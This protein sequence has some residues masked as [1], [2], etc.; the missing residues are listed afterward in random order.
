M[1]ADLP[2]LA[3]PGFRELEPYEPIDPPEVL[4]RELGLPAERIVKLDGNENPYGPS[5]LVG[6]ALARL[7]RYHLYPDPLQRELRDALA[8][9][10]GLGA[11]HIV[12]GSG[13]D[14]LLDVL[15]RLF[16]GPGEAVVISP[17]TFGMYTF[18]A[19][20]CGARVVEVPRRPDL[21]LDVEAVA[22]ALRD[23]ARLCFLASPNNPT[24]ELTPREAVEALLATGALVV[25][26]EAYMEFAEGGW[27]GGHL[28]VRHL[29]REHANLV[30]LRTFSKWAGLA[31]LRVGYGLFPRELA[32]LVLKVK[33]PYNVNVAAQA[34]AL[35]SLADLERLNARLRSLVAERERLLASL[36]G[37]GWLRPY[38]SQANFV[39]CR[40]EGLEA[41]RVWQELRHR[42]ILVRRYSHPTLREY[43]R[44]SVGRPEEN[45]RL[46]A[47]LR[48][49]GEALRPG[50][51]PGR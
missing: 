1:A 25:V 8:R 50:P 37:L 32:E 44:V 49:I 22:A 4:A 40:V 47:A 31:G 21:S 13:S 7:D 12:C 41:A 14:E 28:S 3:R 15:G 43:L 29:V 38:P 20:L 11:E 9:H 6:E 33:M 16:L 2:P 34:A 46:L 51:R 45:D 30:V 39:L 48:E 10:L 17:P 35:A 36:E 19:A 42:G 23:G 5:P 24:G 26:D 18:V 27:P